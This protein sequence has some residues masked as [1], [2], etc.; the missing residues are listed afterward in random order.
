MDLRRKNDS[1]VLLTDL[2]IANTFLS[3]LIGLLNRKSLSYQ[4]GLLFP[5]CNA[6]H[7]IG[8]R[9]SIDVV[10]MDKDGKVVKVLEK[11]PPGRVMFWPVKGAYYTLEVKSG[12][13]RR[14]NVKEGDVLVWEE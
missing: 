8:M 9:F 7:M 2:R 1:K 12:W 11:F 14:H 4:E 3:R 13:C 10:F 5:K 6:I